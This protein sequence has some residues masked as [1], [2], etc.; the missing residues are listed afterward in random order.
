V[1]SKAYEKRKDANGYTNDESLWKSH[2]KQNL[3]FDFQLRIG[4]WSRDTPISI[5]EDIV[6]FGL[7]NAVRFHSAHQFEE[8]LWE[9]I[10]LKV[11]ASLNTSRLECLLFKSKSKLKDHMNMHELQVQVAEDKLTKCG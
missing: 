6:T 7:A 5:V 4:T 9:E 3:R 10:M 2:H 1:W 8:N 11:G